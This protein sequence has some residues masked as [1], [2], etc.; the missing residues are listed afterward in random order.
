MSTRL[1][2]FLY[3][4]NRL[5]T[6]TRP[7]HKNKE[8]ELAIKYAES[9]GWRYKESG[10]S[11]HAWGILLCPYEAREGCKMSI[12]STPRSNERHAKQIKS[13]VDRCEHSAGESNE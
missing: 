3:I 9:K 5:L 10:N 13:N 6:V 7:K 12:W 4:H 11:A 1:L 2:L 8:I